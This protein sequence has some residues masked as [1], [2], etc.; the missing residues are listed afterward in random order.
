MS[1]PLRSLHI[2]NTQK[3]RWRIILIA[4]IVLVLGAVLA[5]RYWGHQKEI[6][7]EVGET[8]TRTLYARVTES[9][10]IEP[11]IDVPVAPDVSGEVVNIAIKEGM[12]VRKGELLVSIQPDDYLAL[13]EQSQASR[14]QAQSAYLRAQADLSQAKANSLQDS[15]SL[16]R[17][18]E[19]FDEKVVSLVELENAQL[20]YKVSLSQYEAAKY[21]VQSAFYQVKNAEASVKQARQNLDRTNIYASMDGTITA[22]NVE[23]GQRVV[24]TRQMAGTEIL[25][26][27][28]LSNME[29]VVEV[30]END[31]VNVNL[32]DSARIEVDAF[33]GQYFYGSVSE[34][35][36]SAQVDGMATTDQVTNFEV[37]VHISP[38]S[39]R[40]KAVSG[41]LPQ[42]T[43]SPFRPGMTALVEVY[44][45]YAEDVVAVPIQAVTLAKKKPTPAETQTTS[46]GAAQSDELQEVVFVL[47][48]GVVREVPVVTGISDDTH[49]E[50]KDGL[51][52]GM[53]VVTGPYTVLTKTLKHGMEV[54]IK[55]S[56]NKNGGVQASNE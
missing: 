38:E 1:P 21:N 28:D 33:P 50:I 2:M 23:I 9:G 20:R 41:E 35:A 26:I 15:V 3:K 5:K 39:Y 47:E 52:P 36:Y 54:G 24:G 18:Q 16:K 49:I 29:V 37:K 19:L 13:L 40:A 46:E 31:I 27:A 45:Q 8:D 17:T 30:N 34:I 42:Q 11:A 43:Q 56:K 6:M 55:P 32:N 48:N 53:Q 4:A 51:S 14:D 44:T 25:K 12:Q 10:M 7:V 22:L